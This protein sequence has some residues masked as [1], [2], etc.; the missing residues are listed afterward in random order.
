MKKRMPKT[1]RLCGRR[2]GLWV[3]PLSYFA[4]GCIGYWEARKS[5]ISLSPDLAPDQM[6]AIAVHELV[7]ALDFFTGVGMT[8]QDVTA[9]STALYAAIKDNPEF[10]AW[11]AE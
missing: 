5:L 2:A 11:V 1:L 7:H 9:F 4:K 6:R 10:V 3:A 8:E